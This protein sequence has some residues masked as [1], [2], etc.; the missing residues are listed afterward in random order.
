MVD[1]LPILTVRQPWA[2]LIV[3]GGKDV[4]NRSW[5]TRYRGRLWIHAAR[6]PWAGDL[7]QPPAA[8][9]DMIFGALIG[10]VK[11][12]EVIRDHSSR[13]AHPNVFHWVLVDPR[14]LDQ[15][16]TARGLPGL[17]HLPVEHLGLND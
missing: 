16:I 4:E 7:E 10:S 11:L 3:Y 12:I 13:W 5:A 6:T 14:P 8:T 15:P 17:W 9:E 2:H 1:N